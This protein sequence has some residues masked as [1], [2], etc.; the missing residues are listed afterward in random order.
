MTALKTGFTLDAGYNL[1]VAASRPGARLLCVVLGAE[2]RGLS[3]LDAGKLLK[4][5]F[6]DSIGTAQRKERFR[7]K[8]PGRSAPAVKRR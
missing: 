7:W 4:Y 3:F 8:G 6:G 2:T 1:A 5:G